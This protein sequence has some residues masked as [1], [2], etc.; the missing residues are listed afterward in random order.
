VPPTAPIAAKNLMI[1][2]ATPL[3]DGVDITVIMLDKD[4]KPIQEVHLPMVIQ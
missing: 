2:G 4:R 3:K 1:A